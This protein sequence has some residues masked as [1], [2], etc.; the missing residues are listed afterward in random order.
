MGKPCVEEVDIAF[1]HAT[2]NYIS[3]RS[4]KRR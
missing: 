4:T 1:I 2:T 3:E